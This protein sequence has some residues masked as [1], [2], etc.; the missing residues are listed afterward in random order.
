MNILF[1]DTGVQIVCIPLTSG[2]RFTTSQIGH[3]WQHCICAP[4]DL[5]DENYD[6]DGEDKNVE[7][8]YIQWQIIQGNVSKLYLAVDTSLGDTDLGHF[9]D[10]TSLRGD[11]VV[12]LDKLLD[13]N[14]EQLQGI[15]TVEFR[16]RAATA[17]AGEAKPVHL[18]VDFGNSRTGA[19]LVEL[20][21]EVSQ[22]AKMMPFELLNRYNLDGWNDQGEFIGRPQ[23]RWFS[24]VTKWCASPYLRPNDTTKKEYYR[25]TV[26]GFLK[27]KTV[28][29]ERAVPVTPDLFQD[30]SMARLGKEVDD[31]GQIMHAKGDFRTSVSSPKRYLWAHDESWLEGAFWYMADPH[32]RCDTGVFAAKIRGEL[33]KYLYEDD[34]DFLLNEK[35]V[36]ED[37]LTTDA[38]VKPR[39]APRTMMTL[40]LYELLCQAF[41][42]VNSE[43][44]RSNSGDAARSREIHSL[45]LTYPSGMFQDERERFTKQAQKAV[46]IFNLSMGKRQRQ[47][48]IIKL[49]LDEASAVH[50]TYIWSELKMLGQDPRLWFA[51]LARDHSAKQGENADGSAGDSDTATAEAASAVA[52]RRRRP[53]RPGRGESGGGSA[54]SAGAAWEQAAGRE[55]RIAC[56]DIGGG[57]TDMMI[58]RYEYEPGIDDSVRGEVLHQ[59]G[60]SIA[61]DQLVKRLLER[62]VVPALAEAVMLEEEDVQLLFGPEVPQNRGFSPQRIDWI[63]RMFVPLAEAYLQFAVDGIEDEEISHTDPDIV[64]PAV[65]ESLEQVCNRLRGPGYYNVQQELKL[66]FRKDRFE[67]I[68]HEVFDDLLFD[69]CTRIVDYDADVVLLA[70]QP[71]KIEY[72]QKLIRTYV[73]LPASRI[74]PMFNHYAGNWYPYQDIK[75]QSPGVIIDPKSAVVVG[76]AIEFMARNGMLPQFKFSMQEKQVENS[77]YWGVMTESTATIRADRVLFEPA[78]ED[79]RDEWT[80]FNSSAQRVIIGR[81]VTETEDAQCNPIYLLKVD[82]GG[83]LGATDVKI[84]VRR[85]RS[86]NGKEEHLALESVNGFVAGEPAVLGENVFFTWRTL[87]DERY[88]LDTGGLDNIDWPQ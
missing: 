49:S 53:Q 81:K 17:T 45:T 33:L 75:G 13:R 76:A 9:S 78:G 5:D 50:L 72:L 58:A 68:V 60:V 74:I 40:A 18:V 37:D 1:A 39:H 83:R 12:Q 59:D 73:P 14:G 61:G 29:Q 66:R 82:T 54:S 67:D 87:A 25:E 16:I 8:P 46:E 26:K 80:E 62:I 51:A 11:H 22:E 47:K 21:G 86:D 3:G 30:L 34:R 41:M 7:Y 24:S 56:I 31:I 65:L 6:D 15:G 20:G 77:Y 69:F 85:N 19:L 36:D 4:P 84:R 32:D 70:G 64:D 88:F 79:T 42:F 43:G 44:Y 52:S 55:L 23:S 10:P 27:S 63:T 71:S 28:T 48:P 35:G 2:R 57:T 38:P